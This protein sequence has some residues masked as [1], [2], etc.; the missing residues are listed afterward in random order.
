MS[1]LRMVGCGRWLVLCVAALGAAST[2]YSE[3]LS[4]KTPE[5][6]PAVRLVALDSASAEAKAIDSAFSQ[7][8]Y[9]SHQGESTADMVGP[10]SPLNPRSWRKVEPHPY[11]SGVLPGVEFYSVL[12]RQGRLLGPSGFPGEWLM[13]RWRGQLYKAPEELMQLLYDHGMRFTKVDVAKWTRLSTLVWM[14]LNR[15]DL[16]GEVIGDWDLAESTYWRL[17]AVPALTFESVDVE[18]AQTQAYMNEHV[19]ITVDGAPLE[20]GVRACEHS[21]GNTGNLRVGI[22]PLWIEE[23]QSG[24]RMNIGPIKEQSGQE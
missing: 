3:S 15:G 4:A 6:Y 24:M 19:R 1:G 10:S 23:T 17:P 5:S 16:Q 20:L 13:A 7:L 22:V 21:F 8:Q 12:G 14:M 18:T 2:I 11:L 9:V